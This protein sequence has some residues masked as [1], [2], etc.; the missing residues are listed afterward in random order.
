MEDGDDDGDAAAVDVCSFG[1]ILY[2]LIV[3]Q[4]V[5][6][7]DTPLRKMHA[8]AGGSE[9][10][11]SPQ[12]MIPGLKEIIHQNCAIHP[13]QFGSNWKQ[14]TFAKSVKQMHHIPSQRFQ[15]TFPGDRM[16][17]EE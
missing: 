2:E 15:I 10:P 1:L 8:L 16:S 3:G 9:R 17:R 4:P 13:I 7:A 5:F 11:E 12:E 6:R 14:C